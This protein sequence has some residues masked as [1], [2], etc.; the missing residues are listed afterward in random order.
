MGRYQHISLYL[1][2]LLINVGGKVTDSQC[3]NTITIYDYEIP[4]WYTAPGIEVFRHVAW[5]ESHF[6]Y[7]HGGLDHANKLYGNG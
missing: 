5:L 3:N 2:T 7:I 6:L 1:G 4:I